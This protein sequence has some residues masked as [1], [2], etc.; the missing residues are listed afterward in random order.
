[1]ISMPLVLSAQTMH[2]S[3]VEINT[4]SK[5]TKT[6][7][8]LTH[9]TLEYHRVCPKWFPC[10]LYVRH[11]S[12][13]EINTIFKQTKMRFHLIHVTYE[14]H[15]VCLKWFT[16]LWYV[17]RKSCT[18]LAPSLTLSPNGSKWA[19]LDPHTWV[20]KGAPEMVSTPMVHLAQIVRLS[21]AEINT[22][23]KW[24]KTSFYLTHVT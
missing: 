9:I 21:C 16:S 8:H 1:M 22:I 18:N 7:F 20:Y 6:R 19:L 4:I 3:C 11:K 2:L 15:R 14:Y 13:T 12:C 17:H 5:Q 23:S 10:V 24:T